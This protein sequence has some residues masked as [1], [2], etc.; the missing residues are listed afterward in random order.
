MKSGSPVSS[1]LFFNLSAS[2][3]FNSFVIH[4]RRWN[5]PS[6]TRNFLLTIYSRPT[7]KNPGVW[8][9]PPTEPA[10]VVNFMPHGVIPDKPRFTTIKPFT[11]GSTARMHSKHPQL[12]VGASMIEYKLN[13]S[14]ALLDLL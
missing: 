13:L 11:S 12:V 2:C 10:N 4:T 1:H 14:T 9:P 5:P 7:P 6:F 3:S 8:L